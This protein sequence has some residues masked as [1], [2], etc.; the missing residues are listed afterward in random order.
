MKE[1][2]DAFKAQGFSLFLFLLFFPIVV[3]NTFHFTKIKEKE[4]LTPDLLEKIMK[5]PS[6]ADKFQGSVNFFKKKMR[7]SMFGLAS[8]IVLNKLIF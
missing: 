8:H 2:A 6:L 5:N 4:W 7:A 3:F 1:S